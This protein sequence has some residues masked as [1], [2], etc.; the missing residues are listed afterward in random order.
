[1]I[2]IR[3]LLLLP[4]V[5]LSLA[6]GSCRRDDPA[7]PSL[8][9]ASALRTHREAASAPVVVYGPAT[10]TRDNGKPR[11][12]TAVF[13]AR[14]GDTLTFVFTPGAEPDDE[15]GDEHDKDR[16][17]E[18]DRERGHERESEGLNAT[19]EVNG[20]EL[21][22]PKERRDPAEKVRIVAR[23]T[24][25]LRVRMAGKP[26][27]S[28]RIVAT[29]PAPA[30]PVETRLLSVMYESSVVGA[31]PSGDTALALGSQ[32]RYAFT[33]HA[34]FRR[35]RVV[36]DGRLAPSSGT[37]TMDRAHWIAASA[38][39][40]IA[41]DPTERPLAQRLR[42]LL[43]SATPRTEWLTYQA[44]VDAA[45]AA[46]GAE[47][48]VHL[49]RIEFATIDPVIDRASLVRVDSVLD[50]LVTSSEPTVT[51]AAVRA[52]SAQSVGRVQTPARALSFQLASETREA[53]QILLVNG[54]LTFRSGLRDNRDLLDSL[55]KAAPTRF[56]GAETRLA[57]FYSASLFMSDLP[58]QLAG[59]CFRGF[60]MQSAAR[61]LSPMAMLRA[62]PS[63]L[64]CVNSIRAENDVSVTLA[65]ARDAMVGAPPRALEISTLASQLHGFLNDSLRHVLVMGHSRGSLL[66]QLAVQRTKDVYG[67]N[68]ETARRCIGTVSVAGV[69]TTN[70]PLSP[71]HSRFVVAR[72]DLVTTLPGI[73]FNPRPTIADADTRA[74]EPWFGA[75]SGDT[76]ATH[77]WTGIPLVANIYIHSFDR[78]LRSPEM[79]LEISNGLD[80]LYRTCAV[81]TVTVAPATATLQVGG[82]AAFSARWV[83]VDGQPLTTAD[84]VQW[85]VNSN[86]ASV[87][88][89]GRVVAGNAPGI[90][91]LQAKVRRTVGAASITIADDSL[92]ALNAPPAVTVTERTW[93]DYQRPSP[94]FTPPF[95]LCGGMR[96]MTISAAA[97]QGA[98]IASVVLSHRSLTTPY[99]YEHYT[100]PL[101][102]DFFYAQ[103][104]CVYFDGPRPDDWDFSWYRL[105]VTDSRGL[106]TVRTGPNP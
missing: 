27:S 2:R 65:W 74:L 36:V 105:V 1:M 24:N 69:G 17:R 53:T 57:S 45:A 60:R 50:G 9:R 97:M 22:S 94:L 73:L 49:A 42:A 61:R 100:P 77:W 39:T 96:S 3:P 54:I 93:T 98:S 8:E 13:S 44:A 10:F 62:L 48:D 30:G 76:V 14:V 86:R 18:R 81:G 58:S 82:A 84:L 75:L 68:E 85:S 34:G 6:V 63:F 31:G 87:T 4:L 16:E 67:F 37:L 70:W 11:T 66:T 41:L 71:R 32:V 29:A 72:H 15:H 55:L 25:T 89:G 80:G 90:V 12:D 26:G 101:D 103:R 52:E 51:M 43:T 5:G 21:Y 106:V 88:Q 78:Y 92:Q 59:V 104:D 56:P 23:A 20:R 64:A 28:L 33:P 79:W 19:V 38:D 7:S 83:A 99:T 102:I 91:A 46:W 47:A 35:L 95:P 40:V